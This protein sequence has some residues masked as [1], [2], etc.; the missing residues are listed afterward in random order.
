MAR[1][2]VPF[3]VHL[4]DNSKVVVKKMGENIKAALVA[5]GIKGA[6][7]IIWQMQRGFGK[8]IWLSGDLQKDM[9]VNTEEGQ[10]RVDEAARTVTIGNTLEYATFVHEGTSKVKGRPY[11]LKGLTG[12]DHMKQLKK[13]AEQELKKGFE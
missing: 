1:E 6:N 12:E 10:Q 9:R 4:Q 11:I 13:A 3:E 7:L 8:S 5:M 2:I